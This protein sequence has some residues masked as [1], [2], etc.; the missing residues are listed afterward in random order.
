[1]S[2]HA[3]RGRPRDQSRER[4]SCG[5]V[6]PAGN[7]VTGLMWQRLRSISKDPL[8]GSQLGR[9]T[10]LRE[11]DPVEGE[12]GFMIGRIIGQFDA[13]MQQKRTA[14][15]PS[16][17]IGR[18]AW[19][20]AESEDEANRARTAT[21]RYARL[22]SE[23][24]AIAPEFPS[25]RREIEKLCIEDQL[26]SPTTLPFV[27]RALRMLAG[28]LGLTSQRREAIRRAH[29]RHGNNTSGSDRSFLK[30]KIS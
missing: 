28:P 29:E 16:Y 24:D 18:R 12:V 5:Q 10:F 1:M 8:L 7:A 11:L 9:L 22:V 14:R 19:N 6:K 23:I 15:A 25:L 26:P 4:Y 2:T 17:E 30:N 3:K 21:R 20:G 13:A 27:R